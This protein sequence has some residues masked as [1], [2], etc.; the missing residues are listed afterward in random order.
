MKKFWLNSFNTLL[1]VFA[2]MSLVACGSKSDS[3]GNAGPA[4]PVGNV[5][6][7]CTNF[8]QGQIVAAPAAAS[9]IMNVSANLVVGGDQARIS[10]VLR[11]G[12]NVAKVYS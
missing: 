12:Q 6:T 10:E 2:F 5:C 8:A 3:G 11:T 9:G 1:G 4:I 7:G